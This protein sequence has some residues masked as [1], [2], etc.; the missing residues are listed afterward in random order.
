MKHIKK[1]ILIT[2][3]VMLGLIFSNTI[4]SAD[5]MLA[6]QGTIPSNPK[7]LDTITVSAGFYADDVTAVK[8]KIG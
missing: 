2:F 5:P 1:Y 8:I 3:I 7:R 4:V 6:S